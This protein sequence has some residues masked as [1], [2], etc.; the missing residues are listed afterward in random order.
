M[1]TQQTI[2]TKYE[3]QNKNV[4]VKLSENG[5]DFTNS[6][7]TVIFSR[8]SN[9]T[10]PFVPIGLVQGWSFTEQRQVEEL[11][12]LGSDVKYTIP[13]R[14]TGSIAITR[15]L[16]NGADTL[17]MLYGLG[18]GHSD[19]ADYF[20]SIKEINKPIDIVFQTFHNSVTSTE[21]DQPHM[22]RYFTECWIV[23]RQES[24]TANQV[25]IAENCTLTYKNI[26]DYST[27][28]AL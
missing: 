1:A 16:I 27:T 10:L 19:S 4:D 26:G 20:K 18:E 9:T 2:K 28:A 8:P 11:F 5:N 12:E 23:A 24:I 25:V 21:A 13:G 6:A 14:T 22:R 7:R 15:M 17:N 3:N